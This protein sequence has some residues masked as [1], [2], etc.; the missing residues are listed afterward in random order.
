MVRDVAGIGD[1]PGGV[2]KLC[3]VVGIG[4]ARMTVGSTFGSKK[5]PLVRDVGGIGDDVCDAEEPLC[6][7]GGIGDDVRICLAIMRI[8]AAI[9]FHALDDL[10]I[11]EGET[12]LE[13][14]L[15]VV[16]GRL[17]GHAHTRE[18]WTTTAAMV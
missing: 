9:Q 16:R 5:E 11:D 8:C 7:V 3:G 18:Q 12:M 14:V 17:A 10:A 4:D 2:G 6:V 15:C 1:D 13:A